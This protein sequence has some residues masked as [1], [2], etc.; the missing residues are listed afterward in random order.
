MSREII[1]QT[2]LQGLICAETHP[3]GHLYPLLILNDFNRF[4]TLGL[5]DPIGKCEVDLGGT[6]GG[7]GF[8]NEIGTCHTVAHFPGIEYVQN[9]QVQASS[10]L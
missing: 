3:L 6:E 1:S 10:F 2:F 9:I 7:I 4:G 5:P 8:G